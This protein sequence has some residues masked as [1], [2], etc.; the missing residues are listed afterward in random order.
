MADFPDQ[1]RADRITAHQAI[2]Q[3]AN[4]VGVPDEL[5]LN[6]GEQVFLAV[7]AL[8]DFADRYGCLEAQ[9]DITS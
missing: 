5:P 9:R 4:L 2:D 6:G 1:E 8:Q 7:Y 3:A